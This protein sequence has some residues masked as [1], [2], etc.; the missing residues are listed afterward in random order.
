MAN[1]IL[2]SGEKRVITPFDMKVFTHAER[3]ISSFVFKPFELKKE[4]PPKN[5]LKDTLEEELR[6]HLNITEEEFE[7]QIKNEYERG[8]K[9]GIEKGFT[10]GKEEGLAEGYQKGFSDAEQQ[11]TKEYNAKKEDYIKLLQ[12]ELQHVQEYINRLHTF[13]DSIDKDIPDIIINFINEIIGVERKINDT[14]IVNMIKKALGKLK[15]IEIS[16]FIVNP[17]DV[18]IVKE[19]F[20]GYNVLGDPSILQGSLKV[21]TKIGEADFS[22]ESIL[23]DLSKSIHEE[24]GID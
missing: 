1:R 17:R 13:M 21:K 22:L 3:G 12:S 23:N 9:E 10:A 2:K 8:L 14:L 6:P 4:E 7:E 15:D 24:L 5:I 19:Y 16:D 11:L 18:E 20:P